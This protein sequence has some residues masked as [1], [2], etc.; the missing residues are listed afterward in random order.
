L[1]PAR[2]IFPVSFNKVVSKLAEF[3]AQAS[4]VVFNVREAA[5][6]FLDEGFLLCDG[7]NCRML[8]ILPEGKQ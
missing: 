6:L 3:C 5:A 8:P 7:G 4:W 2:I 1:L